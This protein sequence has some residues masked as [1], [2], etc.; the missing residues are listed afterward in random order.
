M[1]LNSSHF[2]ISP[3]LLCSSLSFSLV[4]LSCFDFQFLCT[5][6]YRYI[7]HRQNLIDHQEK[8]YFCFIVRL[9]IVSVNDFQTRVDIS[10]VSDDQTLYVGSCV[11][12]LRLSHFLLNPFFEQHILSFRLVGFPLLSPHII[13]LFSSSSTVSSHWERIYF[14]FT[15]CLRSVQCNLLRERSSLE[16]WSDTSRSTVDTVLKE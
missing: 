4:R 1:T 9:C 14:V 15:F 7:S 10:S 6:H 5:F 2:I 16:L 13:K 3:P 11:I 8:F 12:L